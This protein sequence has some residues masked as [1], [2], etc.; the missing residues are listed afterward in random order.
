MTNRE[1]L[2]EIYKESKVINRNIQRVANVG[3]L[4]IFERV[5]KEAE[6]NDDEDG[7]FIVKVG[8]SLIVVTEI[9]LLLRDIM[10]HQ[11]FK[12]EGE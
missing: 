6:K 2:R 10:D 7:K 1:L 8:A 5:A 3:L 9:F 4:G 11:K 12:M